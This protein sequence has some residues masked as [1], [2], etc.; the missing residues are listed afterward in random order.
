[1]HR[2][3][4]RF[5]DPKKKTINYL[6]LHNLTL[7]LDE[8]HTNEYICPEKKLEVYENL[9]S[10]FHNFHKRRYVLPTEWCEPTNY[11]ELLDF[12]TDRPECELTKIF[13]FLSQT[14]DNSL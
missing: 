4:C 9:K 13:I 5:F 8:I 7:L 12:E 1:M 6:H 3:I 10:H 2:H 14:Y 11:C